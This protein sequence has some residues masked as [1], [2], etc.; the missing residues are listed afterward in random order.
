MTVQGTEQQRFKTVGLRQALFACLFRNDSFRKVVSPLEILPFP[1]CELSARPEGRGDP[2]GDLEIPPAPAAPP[3][4]VHG[5]QRAFIA[6]APPKLSRNL[7][8]FTKKVSPPGM[9]PKLAPPKVECRIK[10]HR[11]PTR[12]VSPVFEHRFPGAQ[13][14]LAERRGETL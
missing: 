1:D 7:G 14:F 5:A 9:M 12:F 8:M 11:N 3:F 4:H 2:L 13:Q 10:L 6:N